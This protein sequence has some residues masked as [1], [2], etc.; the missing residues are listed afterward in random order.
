[1]RYA[2]VKGEG[3]NLCFGCCFWNEEDDPLCSKP[4]ELPPCGDQIFRE[5][6]EGYGIRSDELEDFGV[7]SLTRRDA[8]PETAC[9][10]CGKPFE[11]DRCCNVIQRKIF[12]PVDKPEGYNQGKIEVIDFL[13]DK[14]LD[15]RIA[16]VVKYVIRYP[17]KNG[18]EDLKKA[19]WYLERVIKELEIED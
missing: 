3:D 9:V 19:R 17:F 7:S 15:F 1:M 8:E 16:N 14:K 10:M 11:G 18:L 12:D 6:D 4:V 13:E 5:G 2:K